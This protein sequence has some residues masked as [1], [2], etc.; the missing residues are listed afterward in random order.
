MGNDDK[1]QLRRIKRDIK[2]Q[3]NRDRRRALKRSLETNPDEAQFD[4]YE[5]GRKSSKP[6]N[7]FNRDPKRR[8]R[9]EEE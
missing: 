4:A 2:R 6:W 8:E 5:F 9:D 7:G 3:G 1:R